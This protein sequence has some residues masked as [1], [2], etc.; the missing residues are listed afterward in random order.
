MLKILFD[1]CSKKQ[2]ASIYT[3]SNDVNKFHFG[4]ILSVSEED[5][6]IHMF[7]PDGE[8][9]G[10]IVMDVDNV[11]RVEENSLYIKKMLNLCPNNG[12]TPYVLDIESGK[13]KNSIISFAKKEKHIVSIEL[14]ES[15][16]NDIV[17]LIY[18]ICDNQC[19]IEQFDEYGN[20]D[21]FSYVSIE[22]ITKITLLSSEEKRIEKLLRRNQEK[23]G[24]GSMC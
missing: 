3:N 16:F 1:F 12:F 18:E 14:L 11:F 23:T 6:A 19:K 5:I 13:I 8:D 4:Y 17:G 7:S 22:S 9:D 24:D 10:I 20:K 2:I 15:G 21:G